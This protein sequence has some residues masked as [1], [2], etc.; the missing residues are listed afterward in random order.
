MAAKNGK[1]LSNKKAVD[2]VHGKGASKVTY[3]SGQTKPFSAKGKS[4]KV[5]PKKDK[6]GDS[7]L[8]D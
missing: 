5:D 2:I 4:S 8:Y 7:D 3:K 6:M 1:L